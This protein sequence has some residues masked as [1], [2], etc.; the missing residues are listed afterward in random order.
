MAI[1][2]N[3][4]FRINEKTSSRVIRLTD[5]SSNGAG[6]T[7]GKGNFSIVFPDGTSINHTDFVTPDISS[8]GSYYEFQAQTDI[9][10]NVLTGQ[11]TI[12]YVVLDSLNVAQ[13]PVVH[14][15]TDFNWIKPKATIEN[16]SDVFIPEVQFFDAT[17]YVNIGNFTGTVSR[18]FSVPLPTTSEVSGNTAT[19]TSQTLIPVVAGKYYEGLYNLSLDIT[20]NYTHSTYSWLTIYYTELTQETFDIRQVPTQA[21]IVTKMNAF[22]ADVDSYK[23][24]NDTQFEILSEKYD[25]AIALYSHLIARFNTSTLDGSQPLIEELLSILEPY[26]GTYVYKAT[27]LTPFQLDSPQSGY[28]YISSYTSSS[29]FYLQNTLFF[30]SANSALSISVSGNVITFTPNFNPTG[31]TVGQIL[32][33]IDSANYNTEWIDNYTSQIKH[34]VKLGEDVTAGTAVYVGTDLNSSTNMTVYKASYDQEFKS[35]KTMGITVASGVTNGFLFIVTEGLLAG[36][37]TSGAVKGD[38]I[39]LGAN[40]TLLFGIANKPS[41]PLNIVYLGVV[42]RVNQNNGEIFVK[43]QNGFEIEELHNV[44]ITSLANKNTLIYDSS[45]SLWKN[46]NIFGTQGYLPYYDDTLYLKDSLIYTNGTSIGIGTTSLTSILTVSGTGTGGD[47]AVTSFIFNN[48]AGIVSNIQN[49]DVSGWSSIRFLNNLGTRI[50]SVGSGNGSASFFANTTYLFSQNGNTL[51]FAT[52]ATATPITRITITAN[53]GNVLINTTTDAGYKLDVN[54]S[55]RFNSIA[56]SALNTAP[57]TAT[58]T[59]VLGEIRIDAS[60]I[61]VCTASNTWKRAAIT[62]W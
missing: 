12:T 21:Q 52:S 26:G 45:T 49:S 32:A 2:F 23:E 1:G 42:T 57:A 8:I 48:P 11:Y 5:T 55:A 22:R 19:T 54:G 47:S 51:A 6:F 7:F 20:V 44:Q 35:S 41:A 37:N 29:Q 56:L 40:G 33:K 4:Q 38:P 53:S 28:F 18:T 61:Y 62:T 43:I 25:I 10:N 15:I 9:Y 50:G 34:Y 59:G 13:T 3:I 30:N 27:E 17:D 31:G 60:Y 24:K 14:T 36:I 39:W 16:R 46:K 58:S